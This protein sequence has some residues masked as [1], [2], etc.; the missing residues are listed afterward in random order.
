MGLR[1]SAET[2]GGGPARQPLAAHRLGHPAPLSLHLAAAVATYSHALAASQMGPAYPWHPD[3]PATPPQADPLRLALAIGRRLERI[4]DGIDAYQRHPARRT[5]IEPPTVWQRGSA[6][7]L[8]YGATNPSG[9]AG[10][11]GLPVLVLPSLIN[12][13][14]VL[15][16]DA[17]R[18]FLRFLARKGLRP[19]LLDWGAPGPEERSFDLAAYGR[20]RL[21][22]ALAAATR[23]GRRPPA[24]V[25]YCMGGT[26]AAGLAA[27][28]ALPIAALVTLGAPWRFAGGRGGAADLRRVIRLAGPEAAAGFLDRLAEGRWTLPVALFELLFALVNP[29]QV[30][31]KFRRFAALDPATPEARRFV[32]VEDWL[33][34]GVEMALPAAKELLV[35][36]QLK[37]V[38]AAGRWQF[39]DGPVALRRIRVPSLVVTGR[40]D[41]IAP[42]AMAAPLAAKIAEAEHLSLPLGHVGMVVGARA[43]RMC[44]EPVA[45][46]LARI[47]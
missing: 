24:L 2:P 33:A 15:D 23:L 11:S 26:L 25:G 22:P 21:L 42:P 37:N 14:Y 27:A 16:L 35:E 12:R 28:P 20:E 32:L 8:D 46:F 10:A 31:T 18:S 43:E 19:F 13:A 17:E 3:L 9:P 45:A 47:G 5:L 44:W 41:T 30:A 40:R 34:D 1:A 36:W 6:R 38:T 29:V 7:L 39:I 4:L